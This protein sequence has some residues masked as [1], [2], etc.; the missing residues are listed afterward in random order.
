[1]GLTVKHTAIEG[2]F[3]LRSAGISEDQRGYFWK[4]FEE[5]AFAD[6]NLCT[7]FPES[8]V[9]HSKVGVFRGLHFQLPPDDHAKIVTCLKGAVLDYVLDL[10]K[11]SKTFGKACAFELNDKDRDSVYIPTGCAHGFYVPGPSEATL[12]YNVGSEYSPQRDAGLHWTSLKDSIEIEW[13]P[14][15]LS[16]RDG[17]FQP[18]HAFDTPF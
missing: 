13:S 3:L 11:N 16:H 7:H 5:S 17:G 14:E 10:R 1:M 6:E 9:T 15:I 4:L 8:Y 18:F 12:L 2:I